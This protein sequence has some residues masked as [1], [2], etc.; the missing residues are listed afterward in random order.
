VLQSQ[1]LRFEPRVLVDY[2][3]AHGPNVTDMRGIVLQAGLK[4]LRDHGHYDDYLA[5]LPHEQRDQIVH[6]LASSW[7]PAQIY[8]THLEALDALPLSD[9]QLAHLTEPMGAGLFHSLFANLVRAARNNGG[10]GN[11]WF[12]LGHADR[13]FSRIHQGGACKV[14][15][16]GP[17]DAQIDVSGLMFAHL[18]CFRIGHC[19]FLRGVFSYSTKTCVIKPQHG[20]RRDRMSVLVSWV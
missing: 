19:A 16:V 11:V 12:G 20:P 10:E 2:H 15:Q 13:V 8:M 14:T 18:R 1:K 9:A 6:A 7:V 4:Q 17:K 5:R 3:S